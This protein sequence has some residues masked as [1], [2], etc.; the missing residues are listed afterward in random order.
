MVAVYGSRIGF[1]RKKRISE[2]YFSNIRRETRTPGIASMIKI[3]PMPRS[4]SSAP[5]S[6]PPWNIRAMKMRRRH[7]K[8][9]REKFCQRFLMNRFMRAS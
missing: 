8:G 9:V 4:S 6:P 3:T 7:P 1:P 5:G 2:P